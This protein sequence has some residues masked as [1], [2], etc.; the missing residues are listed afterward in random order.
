MIISGSS[1]SF[2]F[3]ADKPFAKPG[4]FSTV[5][6]GIAVNG[7]Q[8]VFIKRILS[9]VHTPEIEIPS[10][11]PVLVS[12]VDVI[13]HDEFQY[14]IYTFINGRQ[15]GIEK[16][17]YDQLLH[18]LCDVLDALNYLHTN[19]WIHGDVRPRHLLKSTDG[20]K[21]IDYGQARPLG[22]GD[23]DVPAFAMIYAAPEQLFRLK[24]LL[25]AD[26]D[27]Y[28]FAISVY[29]I[30]A[31]DVPFKHSNPEMLMHVM[32]MQPLKDHRRIPDPLMKVLRKATARYPFRRPPVNMDADELAVLIRKAKSE[33]Y[34]TADELKTALI[35]AWRDFPQPNLW[36]KMFSK[37]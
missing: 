35:H 18:D 31:G 1:D 13:K 26:T 7:R 14:L 20:I 25:T 27:L 32:L 22:G 6:K 10:A 23:Y 4:K 5:F 37:S 21:L 17:N 16:Y 19:Q 36:R 15:L 29:E 30:L 24:Q 8:D 28:A 9:G 34:Q 33:R 2:S 3:D 11:H 12:L